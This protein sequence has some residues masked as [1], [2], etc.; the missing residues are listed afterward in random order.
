MPS[1]WDTSLPDADADVYANAV[2]EQDWKDLLIDFFPEDGSSI[3][4]GDFWN[5][6]GTTFEDQFNYE[7]QYGA[8]ESL[9]R[10]SYTKGLESYQNQM[11]G[12]IKDTTRK[13]S[14][15]GF[16][17]SGMGLGLQKQSS[18]LWDDY[19]TG[20]T[21]RKNDLNTQML[22]YKEKFKS[23]VLGYITDLSTGGSFDPV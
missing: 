19:Q 2:T 15:M 3:S 7:N 21:Q 9:A 20:L 16:A 5:I 18:S 10:R 4:W 13:R 22:G 11:Y 12:Q 23:D 14:R 17:G 6:H 8:N 1:I